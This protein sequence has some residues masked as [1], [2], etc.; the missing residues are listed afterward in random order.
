[1][2]DNRNI[3]VAAQ[4]I[5]G[6][7]GHGDWKLGIGPKQSITFD[8][9]ATWLVS[10]QQLTAA[11][12]STQL[13]GTVFSPPHVR[14]RGSILYQS[15][16]LHVG[17]FVNYTGGLID[18]RF[19]P[20]GKV[21]PHA[22]LDLATSYIVIPGPPGNPGLEVSLSIDNLFDMHPPQIG[23]TGPTDTPYDSTNY[24]PI[25]RFIAIGLSRH[26]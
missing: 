2:V 22:T 3:N 11:L 4:A 25:G 12:P 16:R 15:E 5:H 18:Q 26:W 9:A 23:I 13:A 19:T 20:V 24:S 17:G 6:I 1:L 21:A 14:A 10:T 8:L 7:D